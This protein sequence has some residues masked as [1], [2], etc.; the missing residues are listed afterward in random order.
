MANF[1][2]VVAWAGGDMFFRALF[3]AGNIKREVWFMPGKGYEKTFLFF[4]KNIRDAQS[5]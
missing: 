2:F 4:T 5:N 1:K 3:G